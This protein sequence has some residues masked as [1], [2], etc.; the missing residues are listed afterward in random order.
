MSPPITALA[1]LLVL[2]VGLGDA[3]IAAFVAGVFTL[4]NTALNLWF[5]YLI[6][7][8]EHKQDRARE[9]ANQSTQ[10]LI[11]L[12]ADHGDDNP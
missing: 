11:D 2:A 7:K 8:L 3:A 9:A 10:A 6:K 12:M 1:G 4:G 5:V